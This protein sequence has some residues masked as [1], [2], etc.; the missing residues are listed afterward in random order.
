MSDSTYTAV[1][2]V[3]TT[4]PEGPA[5]Y[6]IGLLTDTTRNTFNPIQVATAIIV[7]RTAPT[8]S[9][10]DDLGITT[11]TTPDFIFTSSEAGTIR[12][13]GSCTSADTEAVNE[14]NTANIY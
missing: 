10:S 2:T 9:S 7:D 13:A 3:T 6:D 11:D 12:Y 4:T 14:E 1:Y 5:T 8:L